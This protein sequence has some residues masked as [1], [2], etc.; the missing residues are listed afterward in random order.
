MES[1]NQSPHEKFLGTKQARWTTFTSGIKDL[2][3]YTSETGLRAGYLGFIS[4]DMGAD[5]EQT[6]KAQL[7]PSSGPTQ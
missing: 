5:S 7:Q 4:K 6:G 1:R 2:V 3:A